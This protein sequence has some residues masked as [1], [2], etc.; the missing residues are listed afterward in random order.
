M[1]HVDKIFIKL[2]N[3]IISRDNRLYILTIF[4]CIVIIYILSCISS[5]IENEQK[6]INPTFQYARMLNNDKNRMHF[7]KSHLFN[8]NKQDFEKFI[9]KHAKNLK[10]DINE[11]NIE[12]EKEYTSNVYIQKIRINLSAWHDI[13]IFQILDSIENF[14]PGFISITNVA[15]NRISN[16]NNKTK[17][18]NAEVVCDLFFLQ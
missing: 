4:I 14:S 5:D 11:F 1:G 16:I 13:S 3:N 9:K 7:I 8:K 18:L 17:S 6:R 15:I 10:I 2:K 12:H